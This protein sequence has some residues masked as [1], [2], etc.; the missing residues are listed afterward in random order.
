M[1]LNNV[2]GKWNKIETPRLF[3][4]DNP[5]QSD[6]FFILKKKGKCIELRN[7]I[8]NDRARK[9]M[10]I[11][12]T[13]T[14]LLRNKN[15]MRPSRGSDGSLHKNCAISVPYQAGLLVTENLVIINAHVSI[16]HRNLILISD[17]VW[18]ILFLKKRKCIGD[19]PVKNHILVRYNSFVNICFPTKRCIVNS[20]S[21]W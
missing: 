9:E 1:K 15:S 7:F 10:Y 2:C 13:M 21:R 19:I 14:V 8:L 5:G 17:W 20:S 18:E 11:A 4:R 16:P 3:V 6:V 12:H